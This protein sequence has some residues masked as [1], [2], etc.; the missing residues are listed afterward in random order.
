VGRGTALQTTN[1]AMASPREG[2]NFVDDVPFLDEECD[3]P[4][5]RSRAGSLSAVAFGDEDSE[6]YMPFHERMK[7]RQKWGHERHAC[8]RRL[9]A[10]G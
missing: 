8:G 10:L 4:R 2:G 9:S 6:D 5:Q 1:S 7:Q 3:S